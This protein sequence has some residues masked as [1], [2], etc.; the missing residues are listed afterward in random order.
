MPYVGNLDLSLKQ[1]N[2]QTNK[3]YGLFNNK[4]MPITYRVLGFEESYINWSKY[5]E[6]GFT[7]TF[8]LVFSVL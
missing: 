7:V 8:P 1:A 6:I 2:K 5:L 4:F 3:T